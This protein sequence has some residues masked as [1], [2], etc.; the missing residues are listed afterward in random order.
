MSRRWLNIVCMGAVAQPFSTLVR[1]GNQ[2]LSQSMRRFL[3]GYVINRWLGRWVA[4]ERK[5][6]VFLELLL[7]QWYWLL[8]LKKSKRFKS[9]YKFIQ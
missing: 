9:T 6:R 7:L 5:L 2:I 4:L 1:T 3:T 8:R